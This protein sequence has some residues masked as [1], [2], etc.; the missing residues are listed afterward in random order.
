MIKELAK[1]FAG[2]QLAHVLAH[3]L[4]QQAGSFPVVNDFLFF[5]VSLTS[6]LNMAAIWTNA[7]IFL[8]LFYIAY[9]WKR[10]TA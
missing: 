1:F 2:F 7:L 8:V 5:K 4:I 9:F 6:S 3:L 10:R